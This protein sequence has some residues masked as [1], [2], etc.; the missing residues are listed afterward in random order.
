MSTPSATCGRFAHVL[1]VD[2][3]AVRCRDDAEPIDAALH[4]H[5]RSPLPTY[6]YGCMQVPNDLPGQGYGRGYEVKCA[7]FSTG[8]ASP[9]LEGAR[10]GGVRRRRSSDRTRDAMSRIDRATNVPIQ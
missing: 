7:Q 5:D 4:R 2:A 6:A 10:M 9:G 8:E 3:N 1:D